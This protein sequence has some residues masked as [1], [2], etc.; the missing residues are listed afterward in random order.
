MRL[1]VLNPVRCRGRTVRRVTPRFLSVMWERLD[2]RRVTLPIY[3]WLRTVAQS[4]PHP[5]RHP[6]VEVCVQECASR[7]PPVSVGP[8]F[9]RP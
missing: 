4:G 8:C 3:L 9:S 7:A 6:I 2:R 5:A 1:M